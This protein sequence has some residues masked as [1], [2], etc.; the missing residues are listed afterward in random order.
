MSGNFSIGPS[1]PS[2]FQLITDTPLLL[3]TR[4][5][6]RYVPFLQLIIS[7]HGEAHR[8]EMQDLELLAFLQFSTTFL[9]FPPLSSH[10]HHFPLISTTFL[11]FPP[12]SSLFLL[13]TIFS[14]PL[15]DRLN[16]GQGDTRTDGWTDGRNSIL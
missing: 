8:K 1:R 13:V 11:S 10:F 7:K 5:T 12:L 16:G 6:W 14:N 3:I 9:S 2:P 15:V 4:I